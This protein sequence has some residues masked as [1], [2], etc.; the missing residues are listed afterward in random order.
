MKTIKVGSKRSV[1]SLHSKKW[2]DET[3]GSSWSSSDVDSVSTLSLFNPS[4]P[5]SRLSLCPT[6]TETHI[7]KFHTYTG[8]II[9][10]ELDLAPMRKSLGVQQR[11]CDTTPHTHQTWWRSAWRKGDS[12]FTD[13]CQGAEILPA[14]WGLCCTFCCDA[15]LET[16][17][18]IFLVCLISDLYKCLSGGSGLE[19]SRKHY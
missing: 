9:N 15:G 7:V 14:V 4:V 11:C 1:S 6:G 3:T 12:V 18:N 17:L 8:W 10:T 2:S 13:W 16:K 19:A 5:G